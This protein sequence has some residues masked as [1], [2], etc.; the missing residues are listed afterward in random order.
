MPFARASP[1]QST[2]R[3]ELE[4]VKGSNSESESEVARVSHNPLEKKIQNE[5]QA[6]ELVDSEEAHCKR[7]RLRNEN[8]H[9]VI[10]AIRFLSCCFS[11]VFNVSVTGERADALGG[12]VH[13]LARSRRPLDA[14]AGARRN[15]AHR[16][17]TRPC[18]YCVS[19]L[20]GAVSSR[21]LRRVR[22]STERSARWHGAV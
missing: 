22:S 10:D 6:I 2:V 15:G 7:H 21:P 12:G 20:N 11:T 19:V 16:C 4:F 17:A 18:R 8:P 3:L 9:A 14:R 1:P 13:C 5:V